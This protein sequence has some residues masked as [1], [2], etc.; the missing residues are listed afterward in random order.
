MALDFHIST[1]EEKAAKQDPVFSLSE[2]MHAQ[3]F[4]RANELQQLPQLGRM[5]DFCQ[6]ASYRQ[7]SLAALLRELQ[8]VIPL[9]AE[10]PQMQAA[11][12]QLAEV[13]QT[14]ISQGKNVYVFCD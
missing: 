12:R 2:N 10:R 5:S 11:L 7:A 13:C 14:A 4:L 1:D 8:Q 6:D 3:L 9:F